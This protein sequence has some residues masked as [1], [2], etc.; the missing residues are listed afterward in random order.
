MISLIVVALFFGQ[1]WESGQTQSFVGEKTF[2]SNMIFSADLKAKWFFVDYAYFGSALRP[3]TDTGLVLD[4]WRGVN[5]GAAAVTIRERRIRTQGGTAELLDLRSGV[6]TNDG[7][8][9]ARVLANGAV[10]SAAGFV[11]TGAGQSF[12][13]DKGNPGG[14]CWTNVHGGLEGAP[15]HGAVEVGNQGPTGRSSRTGGLDF[16]VRGVGKADTYDSKTFAV[17]ARGNM[18]FQSLAV[19]RM[20]TSDFPLCGVGCADGGCG[21]ASGLKHE[22]DNSGSTT[23]DGTGSYNGVIG[24]FAFNIEDSCMWFCT[25]ASAQCDGGYAKLCPALQ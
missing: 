4:G 22:Y 10:H 16:A 5:D 14:G 3:L 19:S 13:C 1:T 11:H 25:V 18:M 15:F 23:N 7:L 8:S 2:L 20:R 17:D 9:V 6:E 21:P 12:V 24:T